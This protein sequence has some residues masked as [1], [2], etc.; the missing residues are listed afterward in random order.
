MTSPAEGNRY[1]RWFEKIGIDDVLLVGAKTLRLWSST[2]NWR[3]KV[4]YDGRRLCP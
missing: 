3:P 1:I 2:E 4:L